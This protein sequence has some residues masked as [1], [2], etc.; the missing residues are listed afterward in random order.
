MKKTEKKKKRT[1]SFFL[2]PGVSDTQVG[3]FLISSHLVTFKMKTRT[4]IRIN[5][6]AYYEVL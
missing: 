1:K 3:K 2:V 5:T 4:G 6:L